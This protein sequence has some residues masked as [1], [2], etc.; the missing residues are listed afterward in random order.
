VIN[1]MPRIRYMLYA[2]R[3]RG[4]GVEGE[5]VRRKEKEEAKR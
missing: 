4:Y 2:I 1:V 5:R 3:D